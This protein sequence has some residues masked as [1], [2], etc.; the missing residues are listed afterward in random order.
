MASII[1]ASSSG[2]GGI[3]QTA[4]AS[5]VLQL[6]SNG[7]VAFTV[8]TNANVGIGT[9]SPLGRLSVS[10]T[11]DLVGDFNSASA[12]GGYMVW[13]TSG[14]VIADLGTAQNCFGTGG[15]DTFAINGRATRALLLGTNNTERMRISSA[16]YITNTGN[17]AFFAS[18]T[19]SPVA[20]ALNAWTVVPGFSGGALSQKGGANFVASTTTFTA[21]VAG[22]YQFNGSV[23]FS[24]ANGST[25]YIGIGKNAT[26]STAGEINFS[27]ATG[28]VVSWEACVSTC[29]LLAQG[30]TVAL[31]YY[32]TSTSTS[33]NVRT[34]YFSGFLV[35]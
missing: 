31:V 26:S 29:V 34:Q 3:V 16:G 2:S 10:T 18:G 35:G 1:N 14:T 11:G 15:T 13:R 19:S 28:S 25:T 9:T 24:V 22:Y 8:D 20:P 4:D 33:L 30:D 12:N 32:S 23:G 21:P 17:P 6:Q 27:N 7:T 5:G